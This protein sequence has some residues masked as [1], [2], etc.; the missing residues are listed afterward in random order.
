MTDPKQNQFKQQASNQGG[1]E[2]KQPHQAPGHK[3]DEHKQGGAKLPGD[4]K[5][6]QHGGKDK[7]RQSQR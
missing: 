7:D 5:H 2:D 1:R 6:D 4:P 3:Q